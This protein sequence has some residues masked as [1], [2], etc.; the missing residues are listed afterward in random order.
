MHKIES[1][2]KHS[3]NYKHCNVKYGNKTNLSTKSLK[4]KAAQPPI[5][6]NR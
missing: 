3:N 5:S 2:H 1:K 4:T 6:Q